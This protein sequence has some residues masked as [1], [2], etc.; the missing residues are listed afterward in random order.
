MTRTWRPGI[1]AAV[2][3]LVAA[4]MVAGSP[5][6]AADRAVPFRVG[7]AL[8][9]D[10]GWSGI[11]SAGSI[12]ISVKERRSLG[13]A[14]GGYYCLAEARPASLL[15]RLY[16]LY[17]KADAVI[18]T[19]TLQ[20]VWAGLYK[21]ENGS[22]ENHYMRFAG[23]GLVEYEQ[24][25]LKEGKRML[26]VPAGSLDMLSVVYHLRTQTFKAGQ[27]FT[28]NVVNEGRLFKLQTTV[29]GPETIKTSLGP[30]PAW[31]LAPT[32]TDEKGMATDAQDLAIWITN[33][34][35]RLPVKF[36]VALPVGS[37]TVNLSSASS[38]R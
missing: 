16:R 38:A 36:Q 11:V 8:T 35:R 23:R 26:K 3:G 17:Y 31:R 21:D 9:Y 4:Q 34:A 32:I 5:V 18:D 7:E 28:M 1:A 13:G 33:D 20:P 37:L 15:E 22:I 2:A 30:L 6:T 25:V 14:R 27:P 10:V 12:T 24:L 19:S 29:A